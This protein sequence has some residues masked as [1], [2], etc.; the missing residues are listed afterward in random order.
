MNENASV[1]RIR[2]LGLRR[3]AP[4]RNSVIGRGKFPLAGFVEPRKDDDGKP[5]LSLYSQ[6]GLQGR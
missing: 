6:Y 2:A 5:F 1:E 3:F 4:I